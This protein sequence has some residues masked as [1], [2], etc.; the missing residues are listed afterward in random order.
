MKLRF[1]IVFALLIVL[2]VGANVGGSGQVK[3]QSVV[4][5]GFPPGVFQNHAVFDP[6]PGG[7]G[8][9]GL[10]DLTLTGL[11]WQA[12]W[13]F[14]CFSTSYSG[15]VADIV[16]VNTGTITAGTRLQC[17]A[18][19]VIS[20]LVSG[21]ACT[22]VSGNACS[23]LATTCASTCYVYERYDQAGVNACNA[24]AN[25]CNEITAGGVQTTLANAPIFLQ[26]CPSSGKYCM[27][28]VAT[29]ADATALWMSTNNGSNPTPAVNQ[30]FSVLSVAQ[31]NASF[32]SPVWLFGDGNNIGLG[33]YTGPVI[34]LYAGTAVEGGVS[35]AAGSPKSIQAIYNG[36]SSV[37]NLSGTPTT[38][39]S[40][41]GSSGVASGA[42]YVNC[43]GYANQEWYG[44]GP[45]S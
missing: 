38:V 4:L 26:N 15:S 12:Y 9:T 28:C 45:L 2:V 10:G 33:V 16:N 19:G 32:T 21:S 3:A 17:S 25:P 35:I 39:P 8:Y 40:T 24:G 5:P 1:G 23:S 44:H 36:A 14:S 43:G 37:I 27:S 41:P 30:P 13:G 29:G 6:P 31:L 42:E 34:N 22:F 7:A 20:A 11:T 18:G